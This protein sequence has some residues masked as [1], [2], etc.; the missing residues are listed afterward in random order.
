MFGLSGW[1]SPVCV[2]V[3]V[4]VLLCFVD[5][6]LGNRYGPVTWLL[7][8]CDMTHLCMWHDSFMGIARD[9]T[10]SYVWHDYFICLTWFFRMCDMT[11]TYVWRDSFI[12]VTCLFHMCDMP[13]SYVWHDSFIYVTWLIYVCDMTHS[14]AL[15]VTRL[16]HMCDMTHSRVW[17]DSFTRVTWLIHMKIC[18]SE[19][20]VSRGIGTVHNMTAGLFCK[21]A[22]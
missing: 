15:R 7:H 3:C 22:L 4:C 13:H 16:F 2:C 6:I 18:K 1:L 14:R 5:P 20:R 21:R 8:I 11:L 9:T 19:L 10:L 12:C 17:H